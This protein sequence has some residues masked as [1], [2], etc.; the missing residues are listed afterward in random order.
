MEQVAHK[1]LFTNHFSP[2]SS[3][4]S[5]RVGEKRENQF[6]PKLFRLF[7]SAPFSAESQLNFSFMSSFPQTPL[8]SLPSFFLL[9]FAI[10]FFVS[11]F[12]DGRKK[13]MSQLSGRDDGSMTLLKSSRLEL[14]LAR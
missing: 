2:S 8:L 12:F 11:L 13:R 3:G 4:V 5:E 10:F 9:S 7:L 1:D 14:D 6:S